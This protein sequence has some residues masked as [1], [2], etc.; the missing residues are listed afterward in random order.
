MQGNRS[1]SQ[2]E[3]RADETGC[4]PRDSNDKLKE[5]EGGSGWWIYDMT[6]II[7]LQIISDKDIAC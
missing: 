3:V 7:T 5:W 1:C 4:Q 2:K 6:K